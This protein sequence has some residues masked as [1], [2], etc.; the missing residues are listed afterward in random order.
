[1]ICCGKRQ[2]RF[3]FYLVIVIVLIVVWEKKFSQK[4]IVFYTKSLVNDAIRLEIL[5][6][7]VVPRQRSRAPFLLV[8]VNSSPHRQLYAEKRNAIRQTWGQ[9]TR[10]VAPEGSVLNWAVVFMMGKT[11]DAVRDEQIKAESK[12]Y[13]DL[14]I[15]DFKDSYRNITKKLLSAFEWASQSRYS[16]VLK[17][18]DDVYVHIPGLVEWLITRGQSERFYGGVLYQGPV[19][20]NKNHRH[21]VSKEELALVRY[22]TFCKGSLYVLSW[23]LMHD[24]VELARKVGRIT[25]DDAYVGLLANAL[26]VDPVKIDGFVQLKYLHFFI[27]ILSACQLKGIFGFGDSLNPRQMFYLHQQMSSNQAETLLCIS[28][29]YLLPLTAFIIIIL[30]AFCLYKVCVS[31]TH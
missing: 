21:Y 2:I 17:T 19:V 27:E 23:D 14:L 10:P 20:R 7:V 6:P 18:D 5:P 28:Y 29:N 24:M 26:A 1:M 25:P 12:K 13:G 16:Y 31:R 11:Y 22:P 4:R 8:I 15:V 3:F 30:L 9:F